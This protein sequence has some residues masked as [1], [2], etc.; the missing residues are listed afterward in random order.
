M[1]AGA[2]LRTE[3]R[4]QTQACGAAPPAPAARLP[5]HQAGHGISVGPGLQLPR[6]FSEAAQNLADATAPQF[7]NFN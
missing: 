5:G 4:R 7:L 6:L 2:A 3:G 1:T